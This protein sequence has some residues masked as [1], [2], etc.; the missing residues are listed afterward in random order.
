MAISREAVRVIIQKTEVRK[1]I[2]PFYVFIDETRE[3]LTG[4]LR[5]GET[6]SGEE[7]AK[8]IKKIKSQLPGCV[9]KVLFR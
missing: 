7:V 5:K 8:F 1:A 6:L 4:I 2:A 3:Y 9:N